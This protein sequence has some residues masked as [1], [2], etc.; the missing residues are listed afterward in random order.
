MQLYCAACEAKERMKER[1]YFCIITKISMIFPHVSF[2]V[3]SSQRRDDWVLSNIA[4]AFITL[5]TTTIIIITII[6]L[7]M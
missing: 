4:I 1:C 7:T 5:I 6:N 2:E 3:S